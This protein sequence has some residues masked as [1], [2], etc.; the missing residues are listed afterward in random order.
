MPSASHR[1]V[2]SIPTTLWL[3]KIKG[4]EN[5]NNSK[6][7]IIDLFAARTQDLTAPSR[8]LQAT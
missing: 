4:T 5:A 2:E 1:I 7:L 6:A 3:D 8:D